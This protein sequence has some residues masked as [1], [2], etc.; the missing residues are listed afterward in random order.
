M[1]STGTT[2]RARN[3]TASILRTNPLPAFTAALKFWHPLPGMQTYTRNRRPP[4]S[5]TQGLIATCIDTLQELAPSAKILHRAF[6]DAGRHLARI[7]DPRRDALK[8]EWTT[9]TKRYKSIIDDSDVAAGKLAAVLNVYIA[10]QG[11]TREGQEASMITE[12]STLQTV[13]IELDS[14]H[15]VFSGPCASLR[16]NVETFYLKLV[17]PTGSRRDHERASL[18]TPPLERKSE[19]MPQ[20]QESQPEPIVQGGV[21]ANP[22]PRKMWGL[23][24]E[25][26]PAFYATPSP[27]S[28]PA[29][30][31]ENTLTP[32]QAT[33]VSV[34]KQASQGHI[35]VQHRRHLDGATLLARSSTQTQLASEKPVVD[36]VI[37]S[38]K[39][40][41][42]SLGK[43]SPELDVF[44]ELT[45]HVGVHPRICVQHI[46]DSIYTV[47]VQL[48]N[49]IKAYLQVLQS[50]SAYPTPEKRT[51]LANMQG[52]V[53]LSSANWRVCVGA[54]T[55]GYSRV[56]K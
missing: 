26:L 8:S 44:R 35:H 9:L 22:A 43:Q 45:L 40:I 13:D 19:S 51:A 29:A 48:K 21:P 53:A 17:D 11:N 3:N 16:N 5:P 4:P 10:L 32:A 37:A 54:L 38:L 56:Q 52:R 15:Y 7:D 27:Q 6:R 25:R 18:S 47:N 39:D 31:H 2:S 55:D 12:L 34:F 50:A 41:M 42:L 36:I 33:A 24:T 30:D 46:L 23:L 49:E 1:T 14:Y 28:P 20:V